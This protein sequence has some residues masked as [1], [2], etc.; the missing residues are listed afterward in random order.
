MKGRN[1]MSYAIIFSSQTGNTKLLAETVRDTLSKEDC[2]YFGPVTE[3]VPEADTIYLGFWTDRGSA[4]S[5]AAAFAEKLS[6]KKVYL[7]GTAGFGGSEAYFE[8]I[9]KSTEEKLPS[10]AEVIGKFMCVGKMPMSVRDKYVKLEQEGKMPNANMMIENFD[11]ALSHPDAKD[12]EN[13]R[14]NISSH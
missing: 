7:F 12:L 14:D 2:V 8:K 10:D 13:L 1:K 6:G 4:D 3:E 11:K 5:K 9:L